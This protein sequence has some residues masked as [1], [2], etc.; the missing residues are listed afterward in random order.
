MRKLID[1]T[2]GRLRLLG[3]A[4][5]ISLL[6]LL[7]VALPIKYWG[8]DPIPLKIWGSIYLILC[9][10]F[11]YQAYTAKEEYNWPYTR[12]FIALL[13]AILPFGTFIFDI[14]LKKQNV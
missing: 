12:L 10:Q 5:G 7:G 3:F 11:L 14:W 8:G 9:L 6:V 1:T 13:A 4:E 2:I